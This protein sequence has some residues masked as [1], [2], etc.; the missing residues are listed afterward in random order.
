MCSLITTAKMNE[1]DSQGQAWLADVLARTPEL[2]RVA[3]SVA[4]AKYDWDKRG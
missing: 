1:I 2:Q 3:L 4:A